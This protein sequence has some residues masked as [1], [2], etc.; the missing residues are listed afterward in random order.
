MEET[1]KHAVEVE[2]EENAPQEKGSEK[3]QIML[4]FMPEILTKVKFSHPLAVMVALK[5]NSLGAWCNQVAQRA[6]VTRMI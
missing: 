2:K 1:R 6:P 3:A 4:A 5:P